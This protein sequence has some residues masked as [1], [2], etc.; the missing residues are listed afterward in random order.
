[1]IFG[2]PGTGKTMLAERIAKVV[3][4]DGKYFYSQMNK[5]TTPE[6][7]FGPISISKLKED[8]IERKTDGYLPSF[9]VCVLDEVFKSSSSILNTLLNVLNERKFMNNA[10][11]YSI[12][13]LMVIGA[14]NE[15]PT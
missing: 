7:I 15:N 12:K 9:A 3:S 11:E 2:P 5:F 10:E 4:E 1:M 6:E 8:K 13:L 14:S